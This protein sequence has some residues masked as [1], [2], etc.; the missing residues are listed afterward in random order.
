MAEGP[1]K[2]ADTIR[3]RHLER[4]DF[5]TPQ[6]ASMMRTSA[7]LRETY[8]DSFSSPIRASASPQGRRDGTLHASRVPR[9]RLAG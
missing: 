9:R 1:E 7:L 8:R 6:P 2:P 5:G 4:F 3:L